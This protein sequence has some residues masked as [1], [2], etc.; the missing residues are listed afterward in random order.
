M[1]NCAF[2]L[3]ECKESDC[4][5]WIELENWNVGVIKKSKEVTYNK[6]KNSLA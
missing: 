4:H 1:N 5:R 3:K 6:K 2:H